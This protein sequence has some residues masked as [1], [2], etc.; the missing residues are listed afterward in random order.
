MTDIE[1]KKEPNAWDK[2]HPVLR[3]VILVVVAIIAEFFM[4]ILGVILSAN[5]SSGIL[6]VIFA[7]VVPV[8][9]IGT[10]VYT[11]LKPKKEQIIEEKEPS[12]A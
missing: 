11:L 4:I 9:L 2:M 6:V 10:A 12:K 7:L 3:I 5:S 1:R 8:A